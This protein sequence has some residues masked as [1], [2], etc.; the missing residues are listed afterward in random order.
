MSILLECKHY[1]DTEGSTE[2]LSE[3]QEEVVAHETDTATEIPYS[4]LS[5]MVRA[6]YDMESVLNE[7]GI[8]VD[9]I[10]KDACPKCV[11]Y[12]FHILLSLTDGPDEWCCMECEYPGGDV[13]DFVAWREDIDVTE[14]TRYLAER[15]GLLE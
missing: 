15:A 7:Y 2:P 12:N 9:E 5:R 11:T 8:Y 4:E 14:A 6:A 10:G 3:G 13:I 1:L